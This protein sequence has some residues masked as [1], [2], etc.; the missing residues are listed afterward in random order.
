LVKCRSGADFEAHC[1]SVAVGLVRR[2]GL[3]ARLSEEIDPQ[4]V[5]ILQP[6]GD[7][8]AACSA[9]RLDLPQQ[10]AV[11]ADIG[12]SREWRHDEKDTFIGT[13]VRGP[14]ETAAIADTTASVVVA[15]RNL[16]AIEGS[17]GDAPWRQRRRLF[18]DGPV[19]MLPQAAERFDLP[20]TPQAN[21]MDAGHPR[22]Q[23][24]IS[25][26]T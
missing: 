4:F 25:W 17:R 3:F 26:M 14:T 12:R 21:P 24:M 23:S 5:A 1:V 15:E 13:Q 2:G 9:V 7:V 19:G 18:D 22:F 8:E 16:A 20:W 11:D 10:G 6:L